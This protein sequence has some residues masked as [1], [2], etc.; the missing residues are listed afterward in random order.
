[1]DQKID[2]TENSDH[3]KNLCESCPHIF[4]K[5]LFNLDTNTIVTSMQISESFKKFI[6]SKPI[7]KCTKIKCCNHIFQNQK[8]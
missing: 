2:I 4:E 5:I 1:M 3:L 6:E 8:K 7:E